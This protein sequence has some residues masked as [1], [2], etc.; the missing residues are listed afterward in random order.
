[1]HNNQNG[2]TLIELLVASAISLVLLAILA[3]VV[4]SQGNIFTAQTQLNEMQANGRGATEFISRAVANAGYNVF[5]GTKFQAASDHYLSAVYDANNDGIIQNTD[6]MTFATG[7]TLAAV[8]ETITINPFFD[9]DNDGVVGNAETAAYPIPMTLT[10][11]PF[12]IFQ[13]TPNNAGVGVTRA[14]LA[15][16]IDNILIRYYD[17]NGNPLPQGV[18]VDGN[19]DPIPP[20]N[21]NAVPAQMNQIRRVDIQVLARTKNPRPT[22][23]NL[24]TGNYPV[25]TVAAVVTGGTTYTDAFNRQTFNVSQSPRNLSLAP[26]GNMQV[27]I[28]LSVNCPVNTSTVTATL[29][30]PVGLPI[31]GTQVNFVASAAGGT[32]NPV[33]SLSDSSGQAQTVVTYDWSQPSA[34]IPV[35]ASSLLPDSNGINHPVFNSV[36]ASFQSGTGTFTDLFNGG[37]DVN[38]VELD[39]LAYIDSNDADADTVDDSLIMA[40]SGFLARGVNGC[41]WQKYQVEFELTPSI[42]PNSFNANVAAADFVGGYLRYENA[43]SNYSFL[44]YRQP[45]GN[46]VGADGKNYCLSIVYWNGGENFIVPVGPGPGDKLGI[47]FDDGVQYKMLA[48]I[49]DDFIRVKFWNPLDLE[50]GNPLGLNDPNPGNW[51]YTDGTFVNVYRR[52]VQDP[53]NNIA[54]GQIG[55]LGTGFNNANVVFDNFKVT[56]V[57]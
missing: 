47:D 3:G 36:I 48:Q 19:N 13:I 56:P 51:D 42:A 55:L 21:F 28:P 24:P 57:N 17:N 44:I 35:S 16:N 45:G 11:P 43:N 52:E 15:R 53:G 23:Q 31:Q 37:L 30:D 39:N 38:W 41:D 18:A 2:Y 46:C 12:N 4:T 22:N 6:V 20:Y 10:A 25:G 54:S 5:R 1:M 34:N 50:A 49:E 40:P 29:V 14:V 32:V 9:R 26:W 8:T 33:S 7:N 27:A